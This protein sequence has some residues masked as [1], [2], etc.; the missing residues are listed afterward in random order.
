MHLYG[1][2]TVYMSVLCNAFRACVAARIE[3]FIRMGPA[4][5]GSTQRRWMFFPHS[6][7]WGGFR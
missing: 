7:R 2:N 3:S 6:N 5:F 1:G 4:A